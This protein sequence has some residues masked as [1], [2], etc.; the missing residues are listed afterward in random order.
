MKK[1]YAGALVLAALL[2]A[3]PAGAASL[4]AG[5]APSLWLSP[6]QLA[7]G[8]HAKIYAVAYN[9]S[10]DPIAGDMIFTVDGTS[11][12]S[13]HFALQPGASAIESV[14]WTAAEGTHAVGAALANLTDTATNQP[15]SVASGAIAP[16]SIAVSAPPPPSATQAAA[17]AAANSVSDAA[18]ALGG[19]ASTAAPIASSLVS[20]LLGAT[21]GARQ[22]GAAALSNALAADAGQ[23]L[24]TSTYRAAADTGAISF[25]GWS[26]ANAVRGFERAALAVFES[27][28]LFYLALLILILGLVWWL[29]RKLAPRE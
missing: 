16:V 17:S 5:F 1:P 27:P 19:I 24:G 11:I 13:A 25:G 2:A 10:E 8:D 4:P 6:A 15:A 28:A 26:P 21:E 7:G 29:K 9:A 20:D 14:D 23:V 12:G 22:A 18:S 3:A